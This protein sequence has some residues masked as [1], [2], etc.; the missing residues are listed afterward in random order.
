MRNQ[1]LHHLERNLKRVSVPLYVRAAV[2]VF[3]EVSVIVDVLLCFLL[4]MLTQI[5]FFS[6]PYYICMTTSLQSITWQRSY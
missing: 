5:D 2:L 4:S 3:V 6:F 1:I